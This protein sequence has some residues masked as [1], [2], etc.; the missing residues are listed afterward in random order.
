MVLSFMVLHHIGK[1]DQ[2]LKEIARVLRP[3]GYYLF[4]DLALSSP[5]FARFLRRIFKNYGSY[6]AE[7]IYSVLAGQELIP[8]HRE[9]QKGVIMKHHTVV[10]QKRG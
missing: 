2:A 7:E 8:F 3:G 1:W 9:K 5:K 4:N 6:S 10:F